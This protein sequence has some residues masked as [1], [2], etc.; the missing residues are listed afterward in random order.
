MKASVGDRII[1]ASG[2]VGG[3]V[4]DGVVTELH[5]DDGSPPYTVR[6]SDTEEESLVYPGPDSLVQHGD[7]GAA[8]ET[9]RPARAATWTVQLSLVE[10][11][12]STTAEAVLVAG[13]VEHAD[14]GPL[15]SVGH[16][17]KDPHDTEIPVIGDEVAAG[18]ALRRLADAL[19]G[20]A[21]EDITA[22]TG[23]PAHVHD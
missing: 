20:Q 19:L 13:P 23:V 18:R 21:E 10:A 7:A 17:R 1:T 22:S 5:H 8:D 12:G 16:A 14:V 15:R 3:A 11:S 9:A 4:R 2:V 6:W